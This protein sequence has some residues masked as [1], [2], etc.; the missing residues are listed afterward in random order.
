MI[1]NHNQY[2]YETESSCSSHK[3]SLPNPF[4]VSMIGTDALQFL[5]TTTRATPGSATPASHRR[6]PH[7]CSARVRKTTDQSLVS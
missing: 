5:T 1:R 4:E 7:C 6:S 2:F 3:T